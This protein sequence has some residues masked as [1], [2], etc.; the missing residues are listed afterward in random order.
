MPL[1]RMSNQTEKKLTH[2]HVDFTFEQLFNNIS[3][4]TTITARYHCH[5]SRLRKQFCNIELT[6]E[7][8]REKFQ[9]KISNALPRDKG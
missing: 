9:T 7:Y 2:D 5:A 1:F 3:T 6:N 8:N 4:N